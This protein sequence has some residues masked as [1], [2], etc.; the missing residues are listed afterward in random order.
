MNVYACPVCFYPYLYEPPYDEYGY[1]SDEICPCCGFQFGYDDYPEKESA[2]IKWKEK[3]L[4]GG[5]KWFSKNRKPPDGWLL[6]N[7]LREE[8][9]R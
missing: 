9:D 5:C 4:N 6:Q 1:A 2:Y 3:W 8:F 7:Q